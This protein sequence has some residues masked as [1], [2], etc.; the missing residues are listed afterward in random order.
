MLAFISEGERNKA[1][2]EQQEAETRNR[3]LLQKEKELRQ[4][5]RL[6]RV[7]AI[8]FAVLLGFAL[9]I[10]SLYLRE[11]EA[12]ASAKRAQ[13]LRQKAEGVRSGKPSITKP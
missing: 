11:E 7:A 5:K 10:Y 9:V 12:T 13:L 4:Q 1:A 3:E 6:F 2:T 8:F